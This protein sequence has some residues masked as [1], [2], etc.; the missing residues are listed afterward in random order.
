MITITLKADK[1]SVYAE[2]KKTTAYTVAKMA[3]GA[4]TA[5]GGGNAAKGAYDRIFT[6][7][8]DKAML[9]ARYWDEAASM[10]TMS[11]KRFIRPSAAEDTES[12]SVELELSGSYDEALTPSVEKSLFSYFVNTIVGKW[13]SMADKDEVERYE[14]AAEAARQ[15]ILAKLYY[16][17]KPTRVKPT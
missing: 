17:K 8:A 5:D 13:Y 12:Y 15:D 10:M 4:G 16:R 6:T 9:L 2:V 11:L 3:D 14:A 7:E 1:E